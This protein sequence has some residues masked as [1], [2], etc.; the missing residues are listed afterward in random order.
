MKACGGGGGGVIWCMEGWG[1]IKFLH[2]PLG[3]LKRANITCADSDSAEQQNI[4]VAIMS[5][6]VDSKL[7]RNARL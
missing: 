6:L 4:R 7:V 3:E 1:V 5:R 2:P